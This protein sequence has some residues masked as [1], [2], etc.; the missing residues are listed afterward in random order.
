MGSLYGAGLDWV[1]ATTRTTEVVER[2]KEVYQEWRDVVGRLGV[3]EQAERWMQYSGVSCG[4]FFIGE[5]DQGK[6]IRMSGTAAASCGEYALQGGWRPSRLDVQATVITEQSSDGY[7]RTLA[8][9]ALEHI[10]E[11][12]N[13]RPI[14]VTLTE[15]FGHGDTLTLGSRSSVAYGRVYDKHK[16]SKGQYPVGAWRYEVEYKQALAREASSRYLASVDKTSCVLSLVMGHLQ[17]GGI[18]MPLDISVPAD[19]LTLERL[20]AS[21]ER[22]IRWLRTTVAPT[23]RRLVQA[24]KIREV[25]SALGLDSVEE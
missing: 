21:D 19:I 15:S 10:K 11:H 25:M 2:G 5:A 4:G 23:V 14:K 22:S 1:T 6:I 20:E 13:G 3:R 12:S 18:E 9:R 24:G 16:E 17:K 7:A 8:Q